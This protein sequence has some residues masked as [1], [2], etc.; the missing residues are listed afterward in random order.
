MRFY[1]KFAMNNKTK[2]KSHEKRY[3]S[4]LK[5]N[6][7]LICQGYNYGLKMQRTVKNNLQNPYNV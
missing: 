2:N 1:V 4:L 6:R 5:C 7:G 3:L